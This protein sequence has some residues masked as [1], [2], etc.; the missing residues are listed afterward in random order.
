MLSEMGGLC[1]EVGAM[2]MDD[3]LEEEVVNGLNID[4]LIDI[5]FILTLFDL[6]DHLHCQPQE[7]VDHIPVLQQPLHS[8]SADGLR[9]ARKDEQPYDL[10]KLRYF[11]VDLIKLLIVDGVDVLLVICEGLY[12]FGKVLN[13]FENMCVLLLLSPKPLR[14]VF[15]DVMD[16]DE[17]ELF[18]F[19]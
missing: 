15:E 19:W 2:V 4:L 11:E 13:V 14:I 7:I 10:G 18:L 6:N 12:F 8:L 1:V 5:F 9:V 3:E 16:R 17:D